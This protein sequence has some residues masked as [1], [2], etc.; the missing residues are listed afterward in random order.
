MTQGRHTKYYENMDKERFIDV[1][2]NDIPGKTYYRKLTWLEKKHVCNKTT[3]YSYLNAYDRDL[4]VDI[5]KKICVV[6][7]ISLDWLYG[8]S[9]EKYRGKKKL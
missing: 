9:D 7:N 3:I 5:V 6:T 2:E 8:L 4:N 1:L